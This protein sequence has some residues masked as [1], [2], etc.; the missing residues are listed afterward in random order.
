[1][2][3]LETCWYV[4]KVVIAPGALLCAY[5][6]YILGQVRRKFVIGGSKSSLAIGGD[7]ALRQS[8]HVISLTCVSC[9]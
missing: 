9:S 4:I 6:I 3:Y 5:K 8:P 1:M 2:L 7:A